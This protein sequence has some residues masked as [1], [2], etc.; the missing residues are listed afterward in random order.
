MS[1]ARKYGD[2]E[3]HPIYVWNGVLEPKHLKKLG[4]AFSLFVWF[5]D[6]TTKEYDGVGVVLGGSP[7]KAEEIAKSMGVDERT[8]RR[9]MD[10][11]EHHGYIGRT[12]T[13]RGYTIR[14]MKSCKFP[15]RPAVVGQ[16]CPTTEGSGRTDMS[17]MVGQECPP[18]PDKN[19]R[20]NKSKQLSKQK[21]EVVGAATAP[22]SLSPWK[23]L[24][25]NLPMGSPRFQQIFEHYFA[26]RNGNTL[27]D[28]MERA[29]Q[30]ANKRGVGVPP[31][32]FEAKRTVERREADETATHAADAIPELEAEPW[33]K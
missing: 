6:R 4:P 10:R 16:E 5:I 12:L 24:G 29:I 1:Q 11:L 25:S 28:A 19:V 3:S 15:K 18:T 9:R 2:R 22:D 14:I 32:F 20:P 31:K 30:T 33:A 13:P 21:E 27:S 7:V 26:T 8:T 23:V 17:G